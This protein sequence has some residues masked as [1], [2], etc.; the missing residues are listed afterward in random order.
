MRLA[1]IYDVSVT[2]LAVPLNAVGSTES[3][4]R[5]L[6]LLDQQEA[7]RVYPKV[8]DGGQCVSWASLRT[9]YEQF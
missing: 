7:A 2:D 6:H 4:H 9:S 8:A 5:R 3:M 1:A